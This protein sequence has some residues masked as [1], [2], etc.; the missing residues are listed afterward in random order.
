M[1]CRATRLA[2]AADRHGLLVWRGAADHIRV[3]TTHHDRVLFQE[4]EPSL[5][6]FPAVA[7]LLE[8]LLA[9]VVEVRV[10]VLVQDLIADAGVGGEGDCGEVDVDARR[11][12]AVLIVL[13]LFEKLGDGGGVERRLVGEVLG[14]G[15][16]ADVVALITPSG[17]S[18]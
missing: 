16:A 11:R 3:A 7:A 14:A 6:G 10:D 8:L 2:R 9:Q 12:R 4:A 1:G 17:P 15:R 13:I 5:R 18:G